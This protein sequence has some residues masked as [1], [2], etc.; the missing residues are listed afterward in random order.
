VG[1]AAAHSEPGG[2]AGQRAAGLVGSVARRSSSEIS[3]SR[4][5]SP[6]VSP[7]PRHPRQ[8]RGRT[9]AYPV[10]QR[11][12]YQAPGKSLRISPV[13]YAH[14][15]GGRS[16]GHGPSP[17]SDLGA[18]R[19]ERS[20]SDGGR[21]FHPLRSPPVRFPHLRQRTQP[22]RRDDP[23]GDAGLSRPLRHE[24]DRREKRRQAGSKSA[25]PLSIPGKP[26]RASLPI[27]GPVRWPA[28]RRG[29][30]CLFRRTGGSRREATL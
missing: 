10:C 2:G 17:G 18:V 1:Q 12:G 21:R 29:N 15:G 22:R 7:P 5:L 4:D 30:R 9:E 19:P 28:R 8:S 20:R 16:G 14:A 11:E 24:T 6:V 26:A 13:F 3:H 23:Q 25:C 27:S